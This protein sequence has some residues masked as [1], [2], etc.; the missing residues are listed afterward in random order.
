MSGY[1][2]AAAIRP[3]HETHQSFRRALDEEGIEN[4]LGNPTP[5]QRGV[6]QGHA[7]GRQVFVMVKNE[8]GRWKSVGG[9]FPYDG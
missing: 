7:L 5:P 4:R 2:R 9:R 1:D 6:K 8:E 3:D